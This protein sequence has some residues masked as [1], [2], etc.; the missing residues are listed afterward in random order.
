[1][2]VPVREGSAHTHTPNTHEPRMSS[3]DSHGALSNSSGVSVPTHSLQ[4]RSSAAT[5]VVSLQQVKRNESHA[6]T[7]THTQAHM[8]RDEAASR[9]VRALEAK[10]GDQSTNKPLNSKD[11]GNARSRA[12]SQKS[13]SSLRSLE[14]QSNA[15]AQ[16]QALKEV[17]KIDSNDVLKI[18][19]SS[20]DELE[21]IDL[22]GLDVSTLNHRRATTG[23]NKRNSR[24]AESTLNQS[25]TSTPSN[26]S[27]K[28]S[29]KTRPVSVNSF[30]RP[31]LVSVDGLGMG[32]PR[33]PSGMSGSTG[34]STSINR[35]RSTNRNRSMNRSRSINK[36]HIV[37]LPAPKENNDPSL[38]VFGD[39]SD[40]HKSSDD[41][42]GA[43]FS[44]SINV[45]KLE[46]SYNNL[47]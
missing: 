2:R 16:A 3:R 15:V 20:N 25:Q 26:W 36:S 42:F 8:E 37:S 12:A 30:T 28:P 11:Q 13:R 39:T 10:D 29:P 38:D 34:R 21:G 6:H 44:G 33:M 19:S 24:S 23:V 7:Y 18:E 9:S 47:L 41:D 14:M 32:S 22:S 35:S 1:V 43:A 31:A 40:D 27:E 5:S 4:G 17:L 45:N 46:N